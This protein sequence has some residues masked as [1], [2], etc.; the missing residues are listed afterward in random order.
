M[1]FEQTT[2]SWDAWHRGSHQKVLAFSFYS[3]PSRAN[4]STRYFKG[5]KANLDLMGHLYEKDWN[6]RLYLDL[7][8]KDPLMVEAC[9]LACNNSRLDLCPVKKLPN[10]LLANASAIFPMNWR[11]F[12]T[13]DSQVVEMGSRDLDSRFE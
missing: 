1:P 13:L 12:P 10:P 3:V 5:V 2:C 11:F 8:V 7:D 4:K 6:M 9:D